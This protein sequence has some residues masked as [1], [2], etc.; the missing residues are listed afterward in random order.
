MPYAQHSYLPVIHR[1]RLWFSK[2]HR[3]RK[4]S[5][6]RKGVEADKDHLMDFWSGDLCK[7]LKKKGILG[8]ETD[9]AFALSTDGVKVFKSRRDFH[10]W[11]L[12]LINLNL[13]PQERYKR[14]N[15]LVVG[16]VPG[17]DNPKDMDSFLAP[18]VKEFM[19]LEEG[20]EGVWNGWRKTAF[21][22]RAYIC[23]VSGDMPARATLQGFKGNRALRHCPYCYQPGVWNKTVYCPSRL[24]SDVP[25]GAKVPL[26]SSFK[27]PENLH[28]RN[29]EETMKI[30]RVISMTKSED[31]RK[32]YGIN[33]IPMLAHLASID[34][35][36][37]FPPDSMHLFFEN[38]IPDMAAHWRGRFWDRAKIFVKTPSEE[39]APSTTKPTRQRKNAN[40]ENWEANQQPKARKSVRF[41]SSDDPWNLEPEFWDRMGRDMLSSNTDYPAAFGDALRDI[42]EHSNHLKAA[43]WRTWALIIAPIFLKDSFK[44]QDSKD[45]D[46]FITLVDAIRMCSEYRIKQSDVPRIKVSNQGLHSG[47]ATGPERL[48]F[49]PLVPCS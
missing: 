6:Y 11:P 39:E 44:G 19:A 36:R 31:T 42:W 18:L 13:P 41:Q 10:I 38:V 26:A 33:G 16:F 23:I 40:K 3:A 22:L 43:E 27:S 32:K 48:K 34:L 28:M 46:A 1:L 4:M 29:H 30:G 49:I 37:S 2:K 24:P 12:I 17:P 9:L 7:D 25:S 21:T 35:I 20:I 8:N 14:R 47:P 15:I 45:Y 5:T